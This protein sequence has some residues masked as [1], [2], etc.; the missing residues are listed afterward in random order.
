MHFS[1][2][3]VT[4]PSE[5]SNL[6]KCFEWSRA[7]YRSDNACCNSSCRLKFFSH[8]CFFDC[9]RYLCCNHSPCDGRV[10]VW[11]LSCG[12]LLPPL[13]YTGQTRECLIAYSASPIDGVAT[14][15]L[16][17]VLESLAVDKEIA[18]FSS[19]FQNHF[20]DVFS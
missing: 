18:A 6:R 12:E 16:P 5:I 4:S 3:P 17:A 10:E 7:I 20:I 15:S 14:S 11:L 13:L 1:P 9:G 2:M 19:S 8:N